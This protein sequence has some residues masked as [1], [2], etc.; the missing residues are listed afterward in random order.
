MSQEDL[1]KSS[2]TKSKD[3]ENKRSR[4]GNKNTN[5]TVDNVGEEAHE[6]VAVSDRNLS[7]ILNHYFR[8]L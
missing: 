4:S 2:L 1:R 8:W 5:L 7:L 3:S 6:N